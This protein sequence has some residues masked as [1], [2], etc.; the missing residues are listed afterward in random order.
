MIIQFYS[1]QFWLA[2]SL[3]NQDQQICSCLEEKLRIYAKLGD[4]CGFDDVHVEPHLLIKPDSG[5][6][7][8]A[9][10]LLAAAL[11][12]GEFAW[13]DCMGWVA[14]HLGR[15]FKVT[16]YSHVALCCNSIKSQEMAVSKIAKG[17]RIK[18]CHIYTGGGTC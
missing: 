17:H 6:T 13:E 15:Y 14:F 9:A 10:P 8:Q 18:I 16:K 5:E 11:R 12:E 2:E 4:L 7:P 3:S 1:V